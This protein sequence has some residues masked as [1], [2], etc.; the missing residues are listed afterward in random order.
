[1]AGWEGLG[2]ARKGRVESDFME[3]FGG[4]PFGDHVNFS[5]RV[6]LKIFCEIRSK[7]FRERLLEISRVYLILTYMRRRDLIMVSEKRMHDFLKK[8]S[9]RILSKI[10]YYKKCTVSP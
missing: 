1:M 6:Q 10:D 7:I 3:R 9:P 5:E 2:S 8:S 4:F